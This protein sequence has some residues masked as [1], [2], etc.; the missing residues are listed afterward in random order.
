MSNGPADAAGLKRLGSCLAG[1]KQPSA[2]TGET[3]EAVANH[4]QMPYRSDSAASEWT[5]LLQCHHE[6]RLGRSS[7]SWQVF[8][9]PSDAP[10]CLE[11]PPPGPA[12]IGSGGEGPVWG[13][14]LAGAA[15]RAHDGLA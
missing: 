1:V 11:H 13:E 5:A 3:S 9:F 10:R 7:G 12:R 6:L 8:L 4:R 14:C 2:R 15:P